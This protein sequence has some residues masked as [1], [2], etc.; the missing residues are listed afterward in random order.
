MIWNLDSEAHSQILDECG[1][2]YN[3]HVFA[4]PFAMGSNTQT[5]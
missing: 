1:S 3:Y 4:G 2:M 5:L